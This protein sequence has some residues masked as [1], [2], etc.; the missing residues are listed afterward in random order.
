MAVANCH[1]VVAVSLFM[2]TQ[3]LRWAKSKWALGA[4]AW[5]AA[6]LLLSLSSGG[7]VAFASASFASSS[8]QHCEAVMWLLQEMQTARPSAVSTVHLRR[9]SAFEV[10]S[11]LRELKDEPLVT[12]QSI[13]VNGTNHLDDATHFQSDYSSS[14]TVLINAPLLR[15]PQTQA[16]IEYSLNAHEAAFLAGARANRFLE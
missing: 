16:I 1:H 4:T 13:V 6:V 9:I 12:T 2:S 5:L 8:S 7:S 11:L 15:L 14:Q 10:Q 3:S